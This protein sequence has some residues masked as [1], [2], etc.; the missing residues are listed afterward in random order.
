MSVTPLLHD[1]EVK[2]DLDCPV[3]FTGH[4]FLLS[5]LFHGTAKEANI[6]SVKVLSGKGGKGKLDWLM[7]GLEWIAKHINMTARA[8]VTSVINLSLGFDV[9]S[10]NR[11]DWMEKCFDSINAVAVA[12]AGNDFH[13]ACKSIPSRLKN[14]ISV[15]STNKD[16]KI[17]YHAMGSG[18]NYG[19]CVDILAPGD[20]AVSALNTNN[21]GERRLSGTSMAT[22]YVSGVVAQYLQHWGYQASTAAVR[23]LYKIQ[24][25][26]SMLH[27]MVREQGIY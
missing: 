11:F 14:V 12:A 5:G 8:N 22:G 25:P 17:S 10:H 2:N 1:L 18:S 13:D 19:R 3:C 16:D 15:G 23:K 26:W 6:I 20:M 7:Q 9:Q 4:I 21:W 24:L 27:H